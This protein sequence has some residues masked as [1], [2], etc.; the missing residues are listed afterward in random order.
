M[1]MPGESLHHGYASR[2][3]GKEFD[4]VS[5]RAGGHSSPQIAPRRS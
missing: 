4:V 2:L 1:G 5:S 3:I